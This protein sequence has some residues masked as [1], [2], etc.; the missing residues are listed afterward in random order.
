M[1]LYLYLTV[2]DWWPGGEWA[3]PNSQ[4]F[5]R[6]P[7]LQTLCTNYYKLSYFPFFQF[8][9]QDISRFTKKAFGMT[10]FFDYLLDEV[11]RVK[12]GQ[13]SI[14]GKKDNWIRPLFVT[15]THNIQDDI[16]P[17]VITKII[18]LLPEN[19]S[20]F[21][22]WRQVSRGAAHCQVRSL[23]LSN[24]LILFHEPTNLPMKKVFT[25]FVF[26]LALYSIGLAVLRADYK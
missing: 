12:I 25:E 18:S 15:P 4:L 1:T 3:N 5:A 6:P 16:R 7:L 9:F 13:F 10:L 14:Q 20:Y 26:L 24:P 2:C 21:S 8:Y 23:K 19:L 11:I 22:K 17:P